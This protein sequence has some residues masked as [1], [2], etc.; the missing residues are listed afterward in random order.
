[1]KLFF[2]KMEYGEFYDFEQEITAMWGVV[3]R[4]LM[5]S[6]YLGCKKEK[7]Y[8]PQDLEL[9]GENIPKFVDVLEQNIGKKIA[10]DIICDFFNK[11]LC[12]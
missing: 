1:M 3:T 11:E 10:F 4:I 12:Y 5:C 2:G 8:E 6:C 7:D 9:R